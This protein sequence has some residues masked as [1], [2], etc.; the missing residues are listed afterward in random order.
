MDQH[1][2]REKTQL[3]VN[4]ET[5]LAKLP[6]ADQNNLRNV[7][8][9][10]QEVMREQKM[11]GSLVIVGGSINKAWPR[12]DIDIVFLRDQN[13]QDIPRRDLTEYKYALADFGVFRKIIG[14]ILASTNLEIDEN[15]SIEPLIDEEFNSESILRHDGG[16]A[17]KSSSG[18]GT[19]LEFI[20][21]SRHGGYR[22]G[23]I[24]K[25]LPFVVLA[26]N[27]I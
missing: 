23:L 6:E 2:E 27:S 10:F 1:T 15:H 26:E 22:D 19:P 12:K 17:V 16:I 5:Y 24:Q 25:G 14:K 18:E 9:N 21:M 3:Q 7:A 20:R 4:L 11:S 8:R 13:S